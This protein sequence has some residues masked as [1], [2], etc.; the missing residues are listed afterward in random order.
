MY[1]EYCGNSVSD[2]GNYCYKCNNYQSNISVESEYKCTKC[3]S[4]VAHDAKYCHS[5]G[6]K[7]N[8]DENKANSNLSCPMCRKENKDESIYCM[9]CGHKL[10]IDKD[11]EKK[12]QLIGSRN[13]VFADEFLSS[14][15][16]LKK[17]HSKD[18]ITDEE[19]EGRKSQIINDLSIS[20]IHEKPENFLHTILPLCQNEILND[21]EIKFIKDILLSRNGVSSQPQTDQNNIQSI[22]GGSINDGIQYSVSFYT[23]SIP[24]RKTDYSTAMENIEYMRKYPNQSFVVLIRSDGAI[25]QFAAIESDKIYAESFNT[26]KENHSVY[27]DEID[28][29]RTREIV[30][31]FFEGAPV[32]QLKMP[33][34]NVNQHTQYYNQTHSDNSMNT[35]VGILILFYLLLIA[36]SIIDPTITEIFLNSNPIFSFGVVAYAIYIFS[37]TLEHHK[38]KVGVT[39]ILAIIWL[40]IKLLWQYG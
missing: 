4:D 24:E 37:Q 9:E 22:S 29:L 39:V 1:C 30:R 18:I 32:S 25:L 10:N 7:F 35:L 11:S 19:Y 16:K 36:V 12:P 5:C 40:I 3:G 8:N 17:L 34:Q 26:S 13:D 2:S 33:R 14:I 6:D 31:L 15:E 27:S 20:N 23:D 28:V 38:A 21:Q